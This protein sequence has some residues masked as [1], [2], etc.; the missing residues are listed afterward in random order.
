MSYQKINLNEGF[1]S[2]LPVMAPNPKT[3]VTPLLS[4]KT[5]MEQLNDKIN[6]LMTSSGRLTSSVNDLTIFNQ[7]LINDK[8]ALT[9]SVQILID[10]KTNLNRAAVASNN[11][12]DRLE[13][14][15]KIS[16]RLIKEA[17]DAAKT[18]LTGISG[19]INELNT[20]NSLINELTN[21]NTSLKAELFNFKKQ[22]AKQSRVLLIVIILLF[23]IIL[24]ILFMKMR[25]R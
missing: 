4:D 24:A 25:K 3:P 14:D 8:T 23:L 9:K 1:A 5:N 15:N 10:D 11:R 20:A 22:T 13:E 18:G 16:T 17:D 7:E 19:S 12:I 2:R 6:E 21:Q